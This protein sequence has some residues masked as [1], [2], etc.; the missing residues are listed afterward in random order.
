M[1]VNVLTPDRSLNL[2]E[3]ISYLIHRLW[4]V[5]EIIY[6]LNIAGHKCHCYKDKYYGED[7]I[8]PVNLTTGQLKGELCV[9]CKLFCKLERQYYILQICKIM[10]AHIKF[11]EEKPEWMKT[12]AEKQAETQLNL[13]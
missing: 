3:T 5:S 11:L 1:N 10:E 12:K 13:F 2:D 6:A 7:C 8:L 4:R 9:A